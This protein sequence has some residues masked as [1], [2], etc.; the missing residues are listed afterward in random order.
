MRVVID[1]NCLLVS[2]PK[3]STSRWLF[4]AILTG[5][6]EVGVTTDILTE[7]GEII[8]DFYGS[9]TLAANVIKALLGRPT[10]IQISP[11]FFWYS[12]QADVDDNKFVDCAVACNADYLITED[13]HFRILDDIEFPKVLRLTREAFKRILHPGYDV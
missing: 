2:I 7:Y 4:D 10:V 3:I 13:H 11:S 6:I 12:I 8:G 5:R 9:P 1:T